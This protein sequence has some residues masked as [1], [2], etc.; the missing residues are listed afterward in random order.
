MLEATLIVQSRIQHLYCFKLLLIIGHH[1]Y[2]FSTEGVIVH[3]QTDIVSVSSDGDK[4]RI[5]LSTNMCV[6]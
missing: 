4:V 2:F 5:E 6:S 1:C 3:P